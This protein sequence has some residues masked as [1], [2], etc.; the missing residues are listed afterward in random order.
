MILAAEAM[1]FWIEDPLGYCEDV[2][3]RDVC[4]DDGG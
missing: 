4:L 3:E 1:A 2:D